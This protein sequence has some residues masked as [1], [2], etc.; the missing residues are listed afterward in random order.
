MKS[1]GKILIIDDEIDIL[2]LNKTIL[3]HKGYEVVTVG[4]GIQ[5]LDI[6]KK[7]GKEIDVILSDIQ[8]PGISGI[9]F[10]K[11]IKKLDENI[12]PLYFITTL[13]DEEGIKKLLDQGAAGIIQ[14]PYDIKTLT[15]TVN[16]AITKYKK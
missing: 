3:T 10:L 7:Q 1:K 13:Y 6:Y 12:P 5:A 8:L 15:D 14:K 4:D 9:E 2:S 16:S 11:E